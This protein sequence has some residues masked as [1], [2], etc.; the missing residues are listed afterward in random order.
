MTAAYE[1][2]AV[3]T[4]LDLLAWLRISP[5]TVVTHDVD[6][7]SALVKV[8]GH[9]KKN[10]V[11]VYLTLL[12]SVPKFNEP[13]P[14]WTVPVLNVHPAPDIARHMAYSGLEYAVLSMSPKAIMDLLMHAAS[15]AAIAE[16]IG[17]TNPQITLAPDPEANIQGLYRARHTK[18]DHWVTVAIGVAATREVINRGVEYN[19]QQKIAVCPAG[20]FNTDRILELGFSQLDQA[21]A[22]RNSV[23][24]Y[25]IGTY[26][27]PRQIIRELEQLLRR[28]TA[29]PH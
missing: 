2:T 4:F 15:Q 25:A 22:E 24:V 9:M 20:A 13:L 3:N 7:D 28:A 11:P 5:L 16:L 10:H 27:N 21:V 1:V 19:P 29:T 23:P 18:R 12:N 26:T 17:N 6:G 8:K 14:Y